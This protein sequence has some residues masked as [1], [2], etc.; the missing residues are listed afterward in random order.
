MSLNTTPGCGWS[1]T[2]A[3]RLSSSS[4]RPAGAL[5]GACPTGGRGR[6]CG[7]R[8]GGAGRRPAVVAVLGV[9]RGGAASSAS[10]WPRALGRGRGALR[11][12]PAWPAPSSPARG[13]FR[14]ATSGVAMKIEEYAPA[15][16][17]T[18]R[19][20]EM[21]L[22]MPAPRTPPP[23]NS[24][25]ATGSS[26]TTVVLMERTRVPLMAAVGDLA[27][28][29]AGLLGDVLGGFLEAVEDDDR[30]VEGVTEDRQQTDDRA[31]GDLEADQRVDADRDREVVDQRDQGGDRHP[32]LEGDGQV[33]HHED[34][35][36][37]QAQPGLVGD[38]LTPA[39]A[40]QLGVD[41]LDRDVQV[42]GELFLDRH[43]LPWC[44]DR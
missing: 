35:E 30:V 43:R 31:G 25:P 26:A 37:P 17:P 2:S 21:S 10:S 39:R 40:D 9:R 15:A 41:V 38:L 3:I 1:G 6:G 22:S 19:A 7:R 27:V 32:P 23:M 18:N 12:A 13:S 33:E 8:A 4:R 28:G 24:R 5:I 11:L 34:H 36:D 44:P 42:L 16:R 20:S 14:S 29:E